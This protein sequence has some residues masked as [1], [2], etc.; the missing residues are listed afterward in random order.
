VLALCGVFPFLRER[1]LGLAGAEAMPQAESL[2][3]L[4]LS[5]GDP[6]QR[7]SVEEAETGGEAG[8]LLRYLGAAP[9]PAMRRDLEAGL[10]RC[11]LLPL[12]LG[13]KLI[14]HPGWIAFVEPPARNH[15]NRLARALHLASQVIEAHVPAK[16]RPGLIKMGLLVLADL[17]L[18]PIRLITA[19]RFQ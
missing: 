17:V 1:V 13:E 8:A 14:R 11:G 6:F 9:T 16:P 15:A 3:A 19:K 12:P 18:L 2:A 4:H 7:L 10:A 5:P